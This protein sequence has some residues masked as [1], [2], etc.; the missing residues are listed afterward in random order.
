MVVICKNPHFSARE[1]AEPEN[2][3]V[4]ER[5]MVQIQRGFATAQVRMRRL[6]V[7]QGIA[8]DEPR[9]LCAKP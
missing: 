2:S 8:S 4:L 9:W 1:R 6:E 7:F 5:G 3:A